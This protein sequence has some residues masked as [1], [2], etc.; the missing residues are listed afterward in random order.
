[1]WWA[2]F[3]SWTTIKFW[4]QTREKNK[5]RLRLYF[6]GFQCAPAQLTV[7][8]VNPKMNVGVEAASVFLLC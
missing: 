1:M 3:S 6:L 8:Q 7:P 4:T 2:N 5:A